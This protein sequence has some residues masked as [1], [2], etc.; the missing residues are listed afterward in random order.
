V[1]ARAD[2][3]VPTLCVGTITSR[4]DLESGRL[5]GRLVLAFDLDL[6]FDFLA[7]SRRAL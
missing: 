3:I 6:A 4:T 7:P 2:L 5:S 1:D